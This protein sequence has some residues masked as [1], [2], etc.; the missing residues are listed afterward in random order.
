M[1]FL[2]EQVDLASQLSVGLQLQLLGFEVVV[3]PGLLESRLT[4][5]A[6]HHESRQEDRLERHHQRQRRPG[7]ALQDDHP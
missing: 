1:Q 3:G 5:L 2:C 7:V 4:V 6:D